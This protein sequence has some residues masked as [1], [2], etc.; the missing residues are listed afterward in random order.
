MRKTLTLVFSLGLMAGLAPWSRAAAQE[1]VTG[2][3]S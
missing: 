2:E 3:W 1:Q